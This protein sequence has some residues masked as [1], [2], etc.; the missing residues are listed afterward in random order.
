MN[1]VF[2]VGKYVSPYGKSTSSNYKLRPFKD[3]LGCCGIRVAFGFSFVFWD[4]RGLTEPLFY[5]GSEYGQWQTSY[6]AWGYTSNRTLRKLRK[7]AI[8]GSLLGTLA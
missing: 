6:R 1:D 4:R 5:Q 7:T 8:N 2:T 3:G